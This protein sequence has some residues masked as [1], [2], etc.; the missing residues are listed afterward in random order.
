M[1]PQN[2]ETNRRVLMLNIVAEEIMCVEVLARKEI[3]RKSDVVFLDVFSLR[4]WYS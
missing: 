1:F 4:Y 2:F 3:K